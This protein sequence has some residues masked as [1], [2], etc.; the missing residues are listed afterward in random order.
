MIFIACLRGVNSQNKLKYM[1]SF[2]YFSRHVWMRNIW[3]S[4]KAMN[5]S[6]CGWRWVGRG[7]EGDF[8]SPLSKGTSTLNDI[9]LEVIP[10]T[11][12]SFSRPF[13]FTSSL[14]W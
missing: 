10:G 11:E 5:S 14:N 6:K 1:L 4:L 2:I 7:V 12:D 9:C 3:K 13:S 8:F